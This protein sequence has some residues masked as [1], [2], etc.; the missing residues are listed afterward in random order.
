MAQTNA[1]NAQQIKDASRESKFK[2]GQWL[3]D[4]R[5]VLGTPTGRRLLWRLLGKCG[6][7]RSIWHSSAL[8]HYNAGRLDL[9]N[10]LQGDMIRAS[11]Q[12]Y[13]LAQKEAIEAA[14]ADDQ[15]K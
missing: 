13:L 10:E 5:E 2:E 1:A 14:E 8:I 3:R 12:G 15:S 9:G 7:G 6:I 11:S 4:L